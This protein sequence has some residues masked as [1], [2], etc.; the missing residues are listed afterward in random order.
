MITTTKYF[1]QHQGAA[2]DFSDGQDPIC[3]GSDL[4][5]AVDKF[6]RCNAH[7]RLLAISC[8]FLSNEPTGEKGVE[9]IR[10]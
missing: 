8:D 2:C 4:Y 7:R 10:V 1:L 6:K 3:L 9:L 5:I